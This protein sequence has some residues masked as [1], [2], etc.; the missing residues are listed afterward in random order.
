MRLLKPRSFT[1][2]CAAEFRDK[3]YAAFHLPG[4]WDVARDAALEFQKFLHEPE[5]VRRL[6]EFKDPNGK[7]ND[8]WVDRSGAAKPYETHGGGLRMD[9]KDWW[10]WSPRMY[11][12]MRDRGIY[13]QQKNLVEASEVCWQYQEKLWFTIC[14]V[15]DEV[16]PNRQLAMLA[17]HPSSQRLS[18]TRLIVYRPVQSGT[19][20]S[21][22]HSD[23][24]DATLHAFNSRNGLRIGPNRTPWKAGTDDILFFAG[25]KARKSM[26]VPE[27]MHGAVEELS[28]P[29]A[30]VSRLTVVHFCHIN[31]MLYSG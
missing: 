26:G 17:R 5:E 24:S 27:L 25:D 10:H 14:E 18:S 16:I 11:D 3:R 4:S 2:Q 8:G 23:R 15:L 31:H 1:A 30:A 22:W 19:V 13:G 29:E 20:M 6:W 9:E 12:L 7:Q 28:P 21:E